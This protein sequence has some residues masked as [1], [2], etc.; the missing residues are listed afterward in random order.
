M[1]EFYTDL[2]GYKNNDDNNIE[3]NSL[4]AGSK[5]YIWRTRG[6]AKVRGA[7]AKRDGK[8]YRWDTPPKGGHPGEAFGCRCWAEAVPVSLKGSVHTKL[9]QTLTTSVQDNPNKWNSADFTKHFYVGKGKTVTL[10]EIGYLGDVIEVV[11]RVV[12]PRLENQII[13]IIKNSNGENFEYST[14]NSYKELGKIK[15][16][17]GSGTI[18]SF[19]KGKITR[20]HNK[21]YIEGIVSYEYYDEFTDPADLR[22]LKLGTSSVY[23]PEFEDYKWTEFKGTYYFIK[24]RWETTIKSTIDFS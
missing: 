17:L 24:G 11:Q 15:H 5:E 14:S 3:E 12:Y 6:D 23:H 13:E 9:T 20:T 10:S 2:V 18:K 8:T 21:T 16:E 19:T 7:H 4:K 22:Q 1:A